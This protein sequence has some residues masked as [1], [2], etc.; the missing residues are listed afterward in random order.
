M[1]HLVLSVRPEVALSLSEARDI[2]NPGSKRRRASRVFESARLKEGPMTVAEVSVVAQAF[3]DRVA[4]RDAVA[5]ARL[6][7]E[8]GRFLPPGMP[9]CEGRAE[10]Q[11][12]MQQLLDMGV[13]S[14]DIEP[15]DVRQA[16][17]TTIEYGRYTL[18]L[19]LEGAGAVTDVGK[20]VVV[21]E[22]QPDGS[23]EIVL[24]IFNS[25]TPS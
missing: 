18:G 13:S 25:N 2:V 3:H 1:H 17:D 10:I 14:L 20:Y 19:E 15:V 6:Y 7:A 5:L 23:T 22:T 4:N 9:P 11:G 12:A 8:K 21:H 16:G 24:D